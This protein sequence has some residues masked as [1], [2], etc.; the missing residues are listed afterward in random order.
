MQIHLSLCV[1]TK[2]DT[3]INAEGAAAAPSAAKKLWPWTPMERFLPPL[4]GSRPEL[5][6]SST[7]WDVA[8][9]VLKED[10]SPFLTTLLYPNSILEIGLQWSGL[11]CMYF[12]G[13]EHLR[14]LVLEG[15]VM[16]LYLFKRWWPRSP[17]ISRGH[18]LQDC[19]TED[20]RVTGNG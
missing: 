13:Q 12:S 18:G 14:E 19:S 4:L 3:L 9:S 15:S 1:V 17:G 20:K 16:W 6:V 11:T 8:L 5:R 7:I 2:S 10:G